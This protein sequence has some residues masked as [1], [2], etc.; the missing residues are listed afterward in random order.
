[1]SSSPTSIFR[2]LV[3][4][5]E[6]WIH[7]AVRENLDAYRDVA[8]IDCAVDAD[9]ASEL[10]RQSLYDLALLDLYGKDDLPIGTEV[11][12]RM[13][14]ANLSTRVLL[15]TMFELKEDARRLMQL[16]GSQSAWRLAGFIDKQAQFERAL[17]AQVGGQIERFLQR[18]ASILGLESVAAQIKK[19]R[20]RYRSSAGDITLRSN[21]AEIATE[22]DRLIRQLYVDLPGGAKRKSHVS[23]TLKPMERHGLS[24]AV[25][26]NATIEV[27]F[28]ELDRNVGGHKTVLKLGPKEDIFDEAAR[29]HEYVRY[30]VK[31]AQ[32]VELLAVARADALG[33][34][35]YSF[36]GGLYS[37]DLLP[38]D[39]VLVEDLESRNLSLSTTVLSSLFSTT[40]WYA[41][42]ADPQGISDYFDHN[43]STNLRLSCAQGEKRL[44]EVSRERRETGP[45]VEKIEEATSSYLRV[46]T[47]TGSDMI[48]PDASV[49]GW[50]VLLYTAPA[51]LVHGDMHGGNVLLECSLDERSDGDAGARKHHR[52][53]LIDF[54]NAGP[55]PRCIDAVCL[56]SSIRLADAEASSRRH[57][58]QA[59]SGEEMVPASLANEMVDRVETEKALYRAIFLGEGSIPDVEWAQ[60]S[61][62][63]LQ[64]LMQSFAGISLREYLATSVRYAIRNLGF[65]LSEVARYR[66]VAW[67]GAQYALARELETGE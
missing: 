67:L 28:N 54:R 53:C 27:R 63:V 6:K 4:D 11:Y 25:V 32:R 47:A 44:L 14:A 20:G 48:I 10:L 50:G 18:E 57:L 56:E 16:T 39:K 36:A 51:C 34:L 49:L 52:T 43:Y 60:L 5:N 30:G 66:I 26:A 22:V 37:N 35:V 33:G 7:D 45:W 15:M 41:T 8:K 42:T 65:P 58:G 19:Q 9:E 61:S 1:M 21:R 38:L 46:T 3:V 2:I 55:G 40:N 17:K 24:A 64:G 12:R 31:L 62:T 13:D 23:V 29:Y 59:D